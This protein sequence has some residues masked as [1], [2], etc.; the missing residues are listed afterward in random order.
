MGMVFPSLLETPMN[1]Q[2]RLERAIHSAR[3]LQLDLLEL[4]KADNA[5]L[6]DIGLDLVEGFAP[7]HRR[8]ERWQ[9]FS[10]D[11]DLVWKRKAQDNPDQLSQ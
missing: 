1:D 8:I 4:T 7:I 6:A 10:V 5:L 2:E 11:L 9:G 3:F